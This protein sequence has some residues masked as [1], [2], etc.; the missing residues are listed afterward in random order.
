[1]K[2]PIAEKFLKVTLYYIRM[3]QRFFS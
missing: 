1:M 2:V 3:N